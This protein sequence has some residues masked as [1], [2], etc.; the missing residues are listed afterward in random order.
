M[1]CSLVTVR[2]VVGGYVARLRF[3]RARFV[4]VFVS[5]ALSISGHRRID[6][7]TIFITGNI[8]H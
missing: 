5:L 8:T 6:S 7:L 4:R 3:D 1:D 2:H